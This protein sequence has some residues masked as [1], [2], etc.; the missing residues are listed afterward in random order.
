MTPK[1]SPRPVDDLVVLDNDFIGGAAPGGYDEWTLADKSYAAAA[2]WDAVNINVDNLLIRRFGVP[3]W[4]AYITKLY[5]SHQRQFFLPAQEKLGISSSEPPAVRAAKYHLLSNALGGIRTRIAVE[6]PSKAWILYLP[7]TG[8]IGDQTYGE[9]HWLS[10]FPGWHAR[11]GMSLGAPGL[12]F[13]ATHLV[14][15]GDPFTGGYFLDTG[16]P[17]EDPDD[18]YRQAWGEPAPSPAIR[19][20]AE[21]PAG[22]W[23]EGRRLKALRNFAV[24]WAWDRMAT[25]LEVFGPSAAADLNVAVAQ[26]TYAHLP[27]LASLAGQDGSR[28]VASS[29]AGLLD[30]SGWTVDETV[31]RDGSVAIA[32]KRDPVAPRV[33]QLPETLRSLP[34][35]AVLH[36]WSGAAAEAGAKIVLGDVGG[37]QTWTFQ[38]EGAA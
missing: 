21:L 6:S 32:I 4:S 28:G 36:G 8:A 13:V 9:E 35:E 34:Y 7:A 12:V 5:A 38:P 16:A 27:I 26:A 18:R 19:R 14:S 33:A 37:K 20:C 15:R 3:A 2:Y 23:P 11:N 17:V 31:A 10:I 22:D 24:H 29:F 30:M 25:A 1:E